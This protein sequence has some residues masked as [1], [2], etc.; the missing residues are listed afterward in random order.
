[1]RAV[2]GDRGATPLQTGDLSA[3]TIA[4]LRGR[5]HEGGLLR[6]EEVRQ[7]PR[8]GEVRWREAGRVEGTHRG[9]KLVTLG[10]QRLKGIDVPLREGRAL[11]DLDPPQT[12]EF[13]Q[14]G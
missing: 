5:R 7:C 11:R 12:S 8:L 4:H 6:H 1:M 2:S 13:I 10:A 9:V 14:Q 3:Q